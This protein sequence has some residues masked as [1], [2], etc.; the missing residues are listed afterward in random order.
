ML[1]MQGWLLSFQRKMPPETHR[2]IALAKK[3]IAKVIS[4]IIATLTVSR[5]RKDR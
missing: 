3:L 4:K 5:R 1:F 2:K